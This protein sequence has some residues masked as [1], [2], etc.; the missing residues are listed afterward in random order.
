MID[1]AMDIPERINWMKTKLTMK[2]AMVVVVTY[3]RMMP[4]VIV[5]L[6][7]KVMI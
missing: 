4:V 3:Q 6:Q 5:V 1:L 2:M 7:M